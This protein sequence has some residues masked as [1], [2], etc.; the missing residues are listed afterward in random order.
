MQAITALPGNIVD[1]L[2][3]TAA[4]FS[5]VTPSVLVSLGYRIFVFYASTRIIPA[6]NESGARGLSIEP[7]LEDSHAGNQFLAFLS[8]FSPSILIAVY[9]SLLMQHF[10]TTMGGYT[11]GLT[12]TITSWWS[13]N[14]Q[15]GMDGNLWKWINLVATMVLYA[16]ELRL[17]DEDN[18][19]TE[20]WKVD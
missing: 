20:H 8:W 9:T 16:I 6:I 12:E 11:P 15:P 7:T 3:F 14:G 2:Q 17:G 1:T 4:A 13:G 18:I 10:A 19:G 5:A